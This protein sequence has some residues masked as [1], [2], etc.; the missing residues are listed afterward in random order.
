M[1][2][3]QMYYEEHIKYYQWVY[4]GKA[5]WR[6]FTLNP[7]EIQVKMTLKL[8]QSQSYLSILHNFPLSLTLRLQFPPHLL[9][10]R[11]LPTLY[12]DLFLSFLQ[13]LESTIPY[14]ASLTAH[15]RPTCLPLTNRLLILLTDLHTVIVREDTLEGLGSW[16]FGRAGLKE[17]PCG[18][19][20]WRRG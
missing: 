15:S 19:Q 4:F 13:C 12:L 7:K 6:L 2:T 5:L 16:E 1:K 3:K 8:S 10:Q 9:P 17:S 18:R 14:P 20:S 11:H